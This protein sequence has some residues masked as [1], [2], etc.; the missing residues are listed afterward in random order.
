MTK[1]LRSTPPQAQ[2]PQLVSR[3]ADSRPR[4][5]TAA[6]CLWLLWARSR[7]DDG[8]AG[9]SRSTPVAACSR[10]STL[11]ASWLTGLLL[12]ALTSALLPGAFT[13]LAMSVAVVL[14][15]LLIEAPGSSVAG[16]FAPMIAAVTGPPAR[17]ALLATA[18]RASSRRDCPLKRPTAR[19]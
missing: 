2:S 18:W 7:S 15:L 4:T 16:K 5:A 13:A 6:V 10:C 14:A 9:W 8:S 11:P 12:L 1:A 3:R 19:Y 17:C